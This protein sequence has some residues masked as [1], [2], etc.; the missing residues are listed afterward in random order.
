ME[1]SASVIL[2]E[3]GIVIL[4]D[5]NQL[6]KAT[7]F[8]D[9]ARAFQSLSMGGKEELVEVLP[10]LD[11]FHTIRVNHDIL[12]AIL[13]RPGIRVELFSQ[14]EQDR[15]TEN[16][17]ELITKFGLTESSNEAKNLLQKFAT[18]Y[19]SL[20]VKTT[21]ETLDLHAIQ[22]VNALDE[23]DETINT[24]G[25]RL[26]EWYGL[27]FPELDNLLQN[28]STYAHLVKVAGSREKIT[29]DIC[30]QTDLPENKIQIIV[31]MASK[32]RGG[33]LPPETLQTLQ[34]LAD[35]ILDL[36]QL[37]TDLSEMIETIV[38]AIAPNLNNMLTPVIAA[39]LMSRAGSLKRLAFLP[40]STIQVLGAEKALFRAL[41]TG[42]RPPKHGLL[43]QHPA[44]HSAP[45]WHRGK[46]ARAL[47][48]K[49]A[50]AARI[51]LYNPSHVEDDLMPRLNKRIE[52][53]QKMP[54][55]QITRS[56]S[57]DRFSIGHRNR[58]YF[59]KR[60]NEYRSKRKD[61]RR[62]IVKR[63]GRRKR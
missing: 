56:E 27:H 3:L 14:S 44:V 32:S 63:Y 51:D 16:K 31:Q 45:K 39:R 23:L 1:G 22:A 2:F 5:T 17:I 24:I 11:Q 52:A 42:A 41:K 34:K 38:K 47:A 37:R 40:S 61:E 60:T 9:P 33:N 55:R 8:Q 20:K 50:I 28:V 10:E 19:S 57:E 62:R 21:S 59:R 53:I 54:Q 58:D 43:F 25:T 7:R 48:S 13:G 15:I 35:E 12:M 46:I 30:L 4:N 26:R 49:I 18:D 6:V 36:T 29:H